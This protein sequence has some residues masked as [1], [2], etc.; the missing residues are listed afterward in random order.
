[1]PSQACASRSVFT[2]TLPQAYFG[3]GD[4]VRCVQNVVAKIDSEREIVFCRSL[5]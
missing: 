3:G 5:V 4:F 1:M 2:L